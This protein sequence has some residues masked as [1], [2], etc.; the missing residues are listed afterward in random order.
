ML[1]E[2][3]FHLPVNDNEGIPLRD[4]HRNVR[5]DLADRF[6]GFTACE[7]VGGWNGRAA[8]GGQK[9]YIEPVVRYIVACR[10]DMAYIV[11]GIAV[12]AGEEAKQQAVYVV[13][14]GVAEIVELEQSATAEA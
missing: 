10:P 9:T 11:R 7:A 1:K 8:N 12:R 14:D 13:I 4:L 6:G 5:F 3:I 2:C